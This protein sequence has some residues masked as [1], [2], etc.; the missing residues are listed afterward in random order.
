MLAQNP[1][2]TKSDT[3][4]KKIDNYS[5]DKKF[6]KFIHK[7]MFRKKET[8]RIS[9]KKST[10]YINSL[11]KSFDKNSCKIIRKITIETASID[12]LETIIS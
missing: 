5:K 3:V 10:K 2:P 7:I 4:Y 6:F 12:K 9:K 11:Q 8:K 1:V